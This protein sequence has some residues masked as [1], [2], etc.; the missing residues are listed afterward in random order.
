MCAERHPLCEPALEDVAYLS[1]S[2]NRVRLLRALTDGPVSRRRL[3]ESTGVSRTT[4]GR[5]LNELTDRGWVER[6]TDGR[7]VATTTGEHVVRAFLPT[8]EALETVRSLGEAVQWLPPSVDAVGLAAFRDATVHRPVANEP[9]SFARELVDRIESATRFRTLTYLAPPM[10]SFAVVMH[11]RIRDGGLESE[12]V[13]AGGL[14]EHLAGD[15]ERRRRWHESVAFG[16]VVYRYDGHIPC[17]L[18]LFDRTVL[19]PNTDP[20]KGPTGG[21][22]ESD[23]DDVYGWATDLIERYRDAAERVPAETFA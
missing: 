7:Y 14:V 23:D 16:T 6:E 12:F 21:F 5:I 1:R 17:N 13:F 3:M 19:I 4:L 2:A 22:L 8:V 20:D 11:E 10:H 15:P 9:L 18:F